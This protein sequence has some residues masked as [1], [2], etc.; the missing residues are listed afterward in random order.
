MG[1]GIVFSWRGQIGDSISGDRASM[2]LFA[3]SKKPPRACPEAS[4]YVMAPAGPNSYCHIL[5]HLQ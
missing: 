1:R 3:A 2:L 4:N 5:Y